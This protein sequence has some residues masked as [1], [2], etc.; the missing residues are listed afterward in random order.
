MKMDHEIYLG[1]LD[2]D[3]RL[4]KIEEALI[5]A[6]LMEAPEEPEEPEEEK[7]TKKKKKAKF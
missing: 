2:H 7:E 4:G 3:T 1:L 5:K 6:K